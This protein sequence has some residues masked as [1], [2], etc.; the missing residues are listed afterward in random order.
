MLAFL[1][2]QQAGCNFFFGK[3]IK[4][5]KLNLKIQQLVFWPL[6]N[7]IMPM[8]TWDLTGSLL[9]SSRLLLNSVGKVRI[10]DLCEMAA[11]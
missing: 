7:K 3:D 1:P 4:I 6:S 11:T 2:I 9:L 10:S 8:L 5:L